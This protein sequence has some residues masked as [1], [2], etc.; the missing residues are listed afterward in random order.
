MPLSG[1]WNS[2]VLAGSN[3]PYATEIVKKLNQ[4]HLTFWMLASAQIGAALCL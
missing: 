4:A 2:L 1:G 3:F